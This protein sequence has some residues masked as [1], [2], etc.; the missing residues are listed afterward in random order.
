M[1]IGSIQAKI[2]LDRNPAVYHGSHDAVTGK[3][4]LVYRLADFKTSRGTAAV[5]AAELFGPLKLDVMLYGRLSVDLSKSTML[6]K[7]REAEKNLG[8]I[9][10]C[11]KSLR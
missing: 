7:T 1:A 5:T 6:F 8:R 9:G 10:C 11:F 4:C 3:V 2:V